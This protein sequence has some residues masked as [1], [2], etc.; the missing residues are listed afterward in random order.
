MRRAVSSSLRWIAF[1]A[2]LM[3]ASFAAEP[4]AG[5]KEADVSK[6]PTFRPCP[7]THGKWEPLPA[8]T[9]EF[10]GGKLDPAKWHD[11]NPSWKGRLPGWFHTKNVAVRDGKL[12]LTMKK[13]DLPNLPKGY[14][15]YTSAA[16]K[17]RATVRYGYF[18]IKARPMGSKGSS[19]FWFYHGTPEIWTEIDVFEIGAGHPKHKRTVHM[20]AHVFH[21]LVNP[22]R[23]WSK[24]GKWTAPA[25]L[26]DT[27]RV[28]GLE[29]D[30]ERLRYSID[31]VVVRE[32][33][34]THWHQPLTLNFDSET[35]PKWF[36]L[37]EPGTL[38]STFSIDY[39]RAWSR[40]DGPPDDRARAVR[41]RFPGPRPGR[42]KDGTVTYALATGDEGMLLVVAR[43]GPSGQPTRVH[44]EYDNNAY[45]AARKAKEIRRTVV[46]TDRRG[47]A[48][49]FA[50]S[51][52][53]TKG[54]TKNNGY[55]A[56]WVDVA[57]RD[58]PPKG[59][60]EPYAL[61]AEDG[62]TVEMR[63]TF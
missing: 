1:G 62:K 45:F 46:V 16:V 39:V 60:E 49:H 56:L 5:P 43:L 41:F 18:E 59:K 58:R 61:A 14:H 8:L 22:D 38:P 7:L 32:M 31:G 19:A 21:T 42:A 13:E 12:H 33:K 2:L 23:H 53:K 28:Y 36:G 10:E 27:F 3:N 48:V 44:L 15:T 30:R 55:R 26:A 25:D 37:P 35:M 24:G 47:R 54:E 17:S 50:F 52:A 57:P 34:N 11:H 20:N 4:G 6:K 40:L 63:L 9:D 51:W 29:W